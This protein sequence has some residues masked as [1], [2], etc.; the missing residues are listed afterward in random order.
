M[1]LGGM[2]GRL[3]GWTPHNAIAPTGLL[4]MG[5]AALILGGL[6]HGA[7]DKRTGQAKD[8]A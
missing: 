5:V 2:Y 6:L 1:L 4:V 7:A 3:Y 8:A